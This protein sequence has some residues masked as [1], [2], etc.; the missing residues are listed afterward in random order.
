MRI[1]RSHYS[2]FV[3]TLLMAVGAGAAYVYAAITS[4]RPPAGDTWVGMVLGII[5]YLFILFAGSLGAR[6]KV[7]LLRIG[8][9]SCWMKGHLWLG[10][11]ALPLVLLHGAF[12]F[13]GTLT[14]VIMVLLIIIVVSG[15][16]GAILQHVMPK[17]MSAEFPNEFTYDQIDRLLTL[18]RV[19]AYTL[20]AGQCGAIAEADMEREEAVRHTGKALEKIEKTTEQPL[21]GR[22]ELKHFYVNEVRPYLRQPQ[23]S[24]MSLA[25]TLRAEFMFE[26]LRLDVDPAL[27][28]VVQ[29]LARMCH[30]IRESVQQGRRHRLLHAWLVI[31]VPLSMALLVLM[32]VHAVVALYY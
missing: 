4:H 19:E 15:V 23:S 31:H 25:L 21:P 30:E 27:H 29:A 18:M 2:W 17:S 9:M 1:D 8:S 28:D 22:D 11:L 24:K 3:V 12:S 16:S 6:R 26:K 10:L 13:G 5:A 7:L 32:T 20:V 14:T